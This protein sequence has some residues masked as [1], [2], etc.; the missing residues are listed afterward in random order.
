MLHKTN[1]SLSLSL[2]SLSLLSRSPA[3]IAVA[4]LRCRPDPTSGP[5]LR[6]PTS[7]PVAAP[8]CPPSPTS[9]SNTLSPPPFIPPL[10]VHT[11]PSGVGGIQQSP[12]PRSPANRRSVSSR[13]FGLQQPKLSLQPQLRL[14]PPLG[15]QQPQHPS[16]DQFPRSPA[17][18]TPSQHR[19][20]PEP[21][22]F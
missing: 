19:N 20:P 1:G 16:D 10:S 9:G 15:R 2:P 18:A 5:D 3:L 17:A 11:T 6:S 12:P 13:R 7:N 22:D 21:G 4:D 8:R 14:H